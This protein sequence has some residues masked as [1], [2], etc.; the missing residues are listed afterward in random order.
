MIGFIYEDLSGLTTEGCTKALQNY[1]KVLREAGLNKLWDTIPEEIEM[2]YESQMERRIGSE[3]LIPT[4]G[5]SLYQ[6][7]RRQ[8][9]Q[10]SSRLPEPSTLQRLPD[11]ILLMIVS[12]MSDPDDKPSLFTFFALRQVSRRFRRLLQAED[13]ITHPFSHKGCCQLCSDGCKDKYLSPICPP[14]GRHC[15]DYKSFGDVQNEIMDGNVSTEGGW[16][17]G[18]FCE[19]I[20]SYTTC[21]NCQESREDR[22]K[23]GY[24]T[25]CKFSACNPQ[26]FLHCHSCETDHPSLCFSQDQAKLPNGRVCIANEGYIRIC[27]HKTLTRADIQLLLPSE[28]HEDRPLFVTSCDHPEHKVP[29]NYNFDYTDQAPRVFATN[30]GGCGIMLHILWQGHSGS[31]RSILHQSGYLHRHKLNDS[32]RKIRQ[33][34]GQLFLPQR[35]PNALP[36]WNA[37]SEIDRSE[38][39]STEED[40]VKLRGGWGYMNR[41]RRHNLT[42]LGPERIACGHCRY[43]KSCIVIN[44]HRKIRFADRGLSCAPHDWFHAI[45]RKSYVYNGPAGVPEACNNDVCRNHYVGQEDQVYQWIQ[46]VNRLCEIGDDRFGNKAC[47][48]AVEEKQPYEDDR[49]T[50]E[51]WEDHDIEDLE[52]ALAPREQPRR[53][54]ESK[55]GHRTEESEEALKGADAYITHLTSSEEPVAPS[56]PPTRF[57]LHSLTTTILGAFNWQYWQTGRAQFSVD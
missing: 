6:F 15:F 18:G 45:D 41:Q 50:F 46:S 2:D 40:L 17:A 23:A 51:S 43:D 8:K 38:V 24:S 34:G 52:E 27:E 4:R 1:K 35:G 33:N 49:R 3:P 20:R 57:N 47:T 36:E 28:V 13:F 30:Y 37:I 42:F 12:C 9:D 11:E 32:L 56:E 55:E 31:D 21:K 25:T 5:T 7:I 14:G 26:D 53:N 29:C 48:L 39:V 16:G 19:F 44:Y 54:F 22:I 10:V